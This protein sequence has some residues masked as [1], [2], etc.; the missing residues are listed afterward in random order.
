MICYWQKLHPAFNICKSMKPELEE[1]VQRAVELF[2]S[3]YGCCQ[4]V[5]AAFADMYGLSDE[6]AKLVAAGF[7]G[8]V[9]RMR[10]MCGAVSG[11]VVLAGLNDGQTEGADK[12]GKAHCYKVVQDLLA[13]SKAENGSIICA[14]LLGIEGPVPMGNFVPDERNAE[15]YRKRPCG[16]KV[17]SAARI[18]AEYLDSLG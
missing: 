1:R 14:E 7:G 15:Y 12:E 4:S 2:K 13:K 9:G 6:H 8:G 17:E 18:F 5:V 10:M 11:L 3:G 16:A